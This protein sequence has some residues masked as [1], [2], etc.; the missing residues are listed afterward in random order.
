MVAVVAVGV[1]QVDGRRV[2]GGVGIGHLVVSGGIVHDAEGHGR[3]GGDLIVAVPA[4]PSELGLVGGKADPDV[5]R[6]LVIVVALGAAGA[7]GV[8]QREQ[9]VGAAAER[10]GV[11]GKA[12]DAG[13]LVLDVGS[14]AAGVGEGAAARADGPA[15]GGGGV[16][17]GEGAELT[18][19]ED[20]GIGLAARQGSPRL[21]ALLIS[22]MPSLITT[23][24]V[25]VLEVLLFC[26]LPPLRSKSP[27]PDLTSQSLWVA[28]GS[29]MIE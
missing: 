5:R 25:K 18:A 23:L 14:A 9:L 27:G 13:D 1:G 8:S 20:D 21:G 2:A 17:T 6:A 16:D 3:G 11:V 4:D 12:A 24:P 22:R 10:A 7:V 26:V 15:V 28:S 19:V 29:W